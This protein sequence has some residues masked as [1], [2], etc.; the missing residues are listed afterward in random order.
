VSSLDLEQLLKE[1]TG[2]SV[3]SIG[4]DT[5]RRIAERRMR[6]VGL[7]NLSDYL[8]LVNRSEVEKQ[9]LIDDVTVPETW[10]FRDHEPFR[11]LVQFVRSLQR[12]DGKPV[13]ILSVP[14]STGEEPYSIAMMLLD[15]GFD[16][17]SVKI[18]AVDISQRVIEKAIRGLYGN[19][20]FRGAD[21]LYRKKYFR[22]ERGMYVIADSVKEM[23]H[24]SNQ[25]I[26]SPGFL[27][28]APPFDVVLCRNL[29]IYFDL[30]T[31]IK[32]M[33]CLHE[34]MSDNSLLVLGH[35]E[36][37][38]MAEGLFESV[39]QSGT[40]AYR[41]V[42]KGKTRLRVP[43]VVKKLVSTNTYKSSSTKRHNPAGV[44]DTERPRLTKKTKQHLLDEIQTLADQ[45][46]LEQAEQRCTEFIATTPD[47]AQGY[48]LMGL[49]MLGQDDSRQAMDNFKKALYLDSKHYQ[50]LVHLAVLAEEAGEIKKAQNYRARAERLVASGLANKDKA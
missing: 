21:Q 48:Y 7:E 25:N 23:V 46:D 26:L 42:V 17:N 10:F 19:N 12:A 37:G 50:A 18:E 40:F 47:S 45:G 30:E 24:F 14:C 9:T 28:G 8:E 20:S 43:A 38:R 33:T 3:D 5:V 39:R 27:A 29:L 41:K 22:E 31:K 1:I 11:Y 36:T 35:A 6:D 15:A 49:I 32:V 2:L 34:R 16:K 4:A 13:H 44:G